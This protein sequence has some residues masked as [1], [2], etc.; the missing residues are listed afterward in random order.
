[1]FRCIFLHHFFHFNLS[2][3]EIYSERP[4]WIIENEWRIY[5]SKYGQRGGSD[6]LNLLSSTSY[7]PSLI[8]ASNLIIIGSDNGLSP[9]QHQATSH[10]LNHCCSIVNPKLRNT[11]Q[12]NLNQNSHI[13]IQ[14]NAF[15]NVVSKMAAIFSRPQCVTNESADIDY[16]IFT[17]SYIF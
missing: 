9:G 10:Y 2:F 16:M 17:D 11:F 4:N 13:F 12:W 7:T 5:G 1:M 14:E 3:T 6:M 15:E 8:W